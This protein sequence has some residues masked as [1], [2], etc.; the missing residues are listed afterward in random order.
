MWVLGLGQSGWPPGSE[1]PL[2]DTERQKPEPRA[3]SS[4]LEGAQSR[5]LCCRRPTAPRALE[6]PVHF[7]RGPVTAA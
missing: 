5:G 1:E 3:P 6:R 2:R 7:L 4:G